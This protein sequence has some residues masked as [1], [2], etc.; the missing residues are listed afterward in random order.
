MCSSYQRHVNKF[1]ELLKDLERI[2]LDSAHSITYLFVSVQAQLQCSQQYN[3][4]GI[5]N[6]QLILDFW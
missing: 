5:H 1:P 6:S 3:C 4:N 2:I